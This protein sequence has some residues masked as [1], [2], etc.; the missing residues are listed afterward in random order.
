VRHNQ[1][2]QWTGPRRGCTLFYSSASL[3][4][5]VAGH[6]ASS[7]I[8]PTLPPYDAKF[9]AGARVRIAGEAVLQRF[10]RPTYAYHDPLQPS[11][12]KLANS[13]DTV[14]SVGYY[15]GGDVLYWLDHL[16]G[17]WHEECLLP[18]EPAR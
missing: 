2:L 12:L 13:V 15:H 14:K 6:R 4:R 9:P 16:D 8:E 7:V 11:Q 3:A 10:M 17:T 1:P 18:D 5:R